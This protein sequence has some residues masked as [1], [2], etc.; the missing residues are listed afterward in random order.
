MELGHVVMEGDE[1][2]SAELMYQLEDHQAERFNGPAQS[3]IGR[4]FLSYLQKCRHFTLF[5]L[6]T[7]YLRGICFA[8]SA[9][10]NVNLI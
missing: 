10:L 5:R 7:A 2:E 3:F 4:K 9:N 1:V 6:S 8:Q